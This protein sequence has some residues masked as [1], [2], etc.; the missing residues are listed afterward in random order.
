MSDY[1][2][3]LIAVVGQGLIVSLSGVITPGAMTAA[4]LAAGTR[5]R[6]AGGL[7]AVGHGIVEFPLMAMILLGAGRLFE[8]PAFRITVG[9]AGG[10]MLVIMAVGMFGA[11]RRAGN[12][13]PSGRSSRRGPVL[14]GVILSAGNPMFLIWWA[15]IGL[16]VAARTT[17]LG[18][19]A[20]AIFAVLHWLCDFMYLEAM[21]LVTFKGSRLMGPRVQR[22]VLA[23][24]AAALVYIGVIFLVGAGRQL[25]E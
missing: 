23:V 17:R 5:S 20:F 25:L 8:A 4:A 18:V 15:T 22:G 3:E 16:G 12:E 7:M 13:K 21:T 11:L 1:L 9:L 24:C 14:T 2:H 10:A 6:H 19:A